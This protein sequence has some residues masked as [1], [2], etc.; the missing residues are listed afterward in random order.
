MK[1]EQELKHKERRKVCLILVH[2]ISKAKLASAL[3][4]FTKATKQLK[5]VL[6]VA[7]A[8]AKAIEDDFKDAKNE[9]KL[10]QINFDNK[11]QEYKN[12][13]EENAAIVSQT[14]TVLENIT[15]IT[16]ACNV[17]VE[18]KIQEGEEDGRNC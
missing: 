5:D 14:L 16:G 18:D 13:S 1:L 15:K 8:E 11:E 10:A 6:V 2:Q 12:K 3:E 17:K 9:L 4:I 7:D